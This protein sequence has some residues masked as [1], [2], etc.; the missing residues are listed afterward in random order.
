MTTLGPPQDDMYSRIQVPYT[1]V[2]TQ[3]QP[4]G[5][6]VEM[7]RFARAPPLCC[8]S[9]LLHADSEVYQHQDWPGQIFSPTECWICECFPSHMF[10]LISKMPYH[11]F[12]YLQGYNFKCC[13]PHWKLR[14]NPNTF[15]F[16]YILWNLNHKVIWHLPPAVFNTMWTNSYRSSF[17]LFLFLI[18]FAFPFYFSTI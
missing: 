8:W 11:K 15:S 1:F 4:W 10:E 5:L 6:W 9:S 14:L 3:R 18:K 17:T 12:K 16:K 13:C 2:K 7:R